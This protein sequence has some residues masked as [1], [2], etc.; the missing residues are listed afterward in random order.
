[1]IGSALGGTEILSTSSN[2]IY[3]SHNLCTDIVPMALDVFLFYLTAKM[4]HGDSNMPILVPAQKRYAPPSD[5]IDHTVRTHMIHA[6]RRDQ[7]LS[8]LRTSFALQWKPTDS[9]RAP[10]TATPLTPPAAHL[11]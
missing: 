8:Q 7:Q 1:M 3:A 10:A 9:M 11:K 6:N 5:N 2:I 4:H